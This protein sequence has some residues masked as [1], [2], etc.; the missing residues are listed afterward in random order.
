[1]MSVSVRVE[2]ARQDEVERMLRLGEHF[3]LALYPPEACFLLDIA[4]LD[5]PDIDVFIARDDEDASPAPAPAPAPAA[6]PAGAHPSAG[7]ALG[8]V[9]L[10]DRGDGT[11]EIKRMFVLESARG[12]GVARSLLGALEA[13]ASVRGIR[14]L[15]LETGTHH[16]A[17]LALYSS[18]G[19]LHI[20]RFGPYSAS[21]FSVCME[22]S[23]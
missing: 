8:M 9:A 19:Y 10:V 17:A 20:A 13:G 22:K 4:E 23:L 15:Q 6:A 11:G 2:P 7:S 14:L 16:T 12:R 21:E 1:M 5:A 3:A 18:L